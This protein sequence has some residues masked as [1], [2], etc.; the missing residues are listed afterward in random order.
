MLDARSAD[1]SVVGVRRSPLG[2]VIVGIS[3]L[4]GV[5]L[6]PACSSQAALVGQGGQCEL[7]SDCQNGLICAPQQTGASMCPC[8][9]TSD[10]SGVQ[11][12]PPSTDAGGAN[13]DA[14]AAPGPEAGMTANDA[15]ATSDDAGGSAP[16][17]SVLSD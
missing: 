8:V 16:D 7:A 17:A 2:I 5:A 9:C 14:G 3:A 15:G 10:L 6:V 11:K 1:R 12:L 4:S 13:K